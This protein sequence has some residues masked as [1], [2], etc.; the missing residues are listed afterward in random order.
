MPDFSDDSDNKYKKNSLLHELDETETGS[1]SGETGAASG[2]GGQSGQIEFKDFLASTENVRDDLL[3]GEEKKRLLSVHENVHEARVKKQKALKEQRQ[4]V[5]EGKISVQDYRQGLG[6]SGHS[7]Y[8]IN[9]ILADKA[10]FSGI[11]RQENPL[12]NENIAETNQE[13]RQ[14]LDLQ[15][16]LRYQPQNAPKFNPRPSPF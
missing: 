5:K 12:P 14:E 9:P 13:Q 3:S 10:Q 15:Y 4:A 1:D 16:R 7:Q 2:T 6:N 8:K 11:D